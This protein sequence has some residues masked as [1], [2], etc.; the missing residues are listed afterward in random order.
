MFQR[1]LC[2]LSPRKMFICLFINN[3]HSQILITCRESP[4]GVMVN[5]PREF[6]H[7]SGYDTCYLVTYNQ[8][9]LC[10]DYFSRHGYCYSKRF[11][12]PAFAD[13]FLREFQLQQVSSSLQGFSQYSGR[14]VIILVLW[15]LS[16][17]VPS[18]IL[19]GLFQVHQLQLV[20][21]PLSC[22]IIFQF[23]SKIKIF[24]SLFAFF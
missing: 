6:P 2:I 11:F 4:C 12:T 17:F 22:F 19:W 7:Q 3:L 16:L 1:I 23:S 18:L 14:S 8:Y 15:F 20:S 5:V 21:P 13:G 24:I 9:L 10:N